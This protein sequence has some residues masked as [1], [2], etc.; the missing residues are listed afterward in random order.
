MSTRRAFLGTL[1]R[2]IGGGGLLLALIGNGALALPSDLGK[3]ATLPLSPVPM[4]ISPVGQ[5]L[6]ELRRELAAVHDLPHS[7]HRSSRW[8]ELLQ[9]YAVDADILSQRK[10]TTWAD[11]VE[12]A[13][14]AWHFAPKAFSD[15]GD[16]LAYSGALDAGRSPGSHEWDHWPT[17]VRAAFIEAVLTLGNG[18][19]F[20]P[21]IKEARHG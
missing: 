8:R 7:Q 16:G 18:D 6:R 12:L 11:C 3:A 2:T 13:E 1:G 4:P 20:D 5:E 19:R 9:I 15:R 10:P 21:Q 17:R 14:V